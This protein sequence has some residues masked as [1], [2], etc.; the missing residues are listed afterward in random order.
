MQQ[1]SSCSTPPLPTRPLHPDPLEAAPSFFHFLCGW[2]FDEGEI[3]LDEF[4]IEF[5]LKR[6]APTSQME[7]RARL[8]LRVSIEGCS[9][10]VGVASCRCCCCRCWL[11]RAASPASIPVRC[12]TQACCTTWPAGTPTGALSK[13]GWP[14][15]T[16]SVPLPPR[17]GLLYETGLVLSASSSLP[18]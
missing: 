5:F 9:V 6:G 17:A 14:C 2:T 7:V 15:I 1:Q 16:P 3:S 12:R 8:W 13:H 4:V 10:A 11:N 18:A